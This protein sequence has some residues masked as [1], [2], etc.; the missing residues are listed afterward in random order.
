MALDK[1]I[2]KKAIEIETE[3]C[4]KEVIRQKERFGDEHEIVFVPVMV[5]EHNG[6]IG[7][8]TYSDIMKTYNQLTR[9]E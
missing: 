2:I 7:R 3:Q 6:K 9:E 5:K 8:I 1:K 4:E